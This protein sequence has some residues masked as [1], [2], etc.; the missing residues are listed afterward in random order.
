[1]GKTEG[2]SIKSGMRQ[3]YLVSPLLFNTVLEILD[4]AIGKKKK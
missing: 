4:R 1:M 2:S 3:R